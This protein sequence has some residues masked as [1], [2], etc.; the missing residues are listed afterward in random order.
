LNYR[1][2]FGKPVK[3]ILQLQDAFFVLIILLTVLFYKEPLAQDFVRENDSFRKLDLITHS[4]KDSIKTKDSADVEFRMTKSP[5][6]AILY[7]MALPGA[8]QYYNKSYWKIP[9]IWAFGGYF[10]YEIANNNNKYLDYRE[11]F[12]KSQAV[13]GPF[14]DTRLKILR[15]FY[16]DQRDQFY[17]YAGLV[18][19]INIVDAYVDAHLF[20][21]DV[22][23][24][25]K[26]GVSG[27]PGK[28]LNLNINF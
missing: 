14:G 10:I 4:L 20:D 7:S 25:M 3:S 22:S 12:V 28:L 26:L 23:D 13:Y 17:L 6:K 18:Y 2:K 19:L 15:D 8:G 5:L 21:F 11:A 16:R 24:K 1:L 27:N 9:V